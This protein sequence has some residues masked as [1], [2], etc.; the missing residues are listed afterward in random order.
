MQTFGIIDCPA[1]PH[2]L[3]VLKFFGRTSQLWVSCMEGHVGHVKGNIVYWHKTMMMVLNV[4][5]CVQH[6]FVLYGT[7]FPSVWNIVSSVERFSLQCGT[8]FL[9]VVYNLIWNE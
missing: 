8:L 7:L 3:P 5:Y 9:M 4:S 6:C 2:L 1:E